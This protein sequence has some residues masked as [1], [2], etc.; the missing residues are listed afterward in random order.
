MASASLE[1]R[2]IPHEI[3]ERVFSCCDVPTLAVV[4]RTNF[5]CLELS[6]KYLYSDIVLDDMEKALILVRLSVSEPLPA[7]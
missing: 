6:S 1:D 2:Y 7:P 5:L 3:L 4:A